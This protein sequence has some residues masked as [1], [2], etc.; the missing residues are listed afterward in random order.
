MYTFGHAHVHDAY[1]GSMDGRTDGWM[2]GGVN[3]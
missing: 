2:D 3:G 1:G